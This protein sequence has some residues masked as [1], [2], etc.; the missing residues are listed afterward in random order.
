MGKNSTNDKWKFAASVV[1][2]RKFEGKETEILIN[3][4]LISA[5]KLKKEISRYTCPRFEAEV[6]SGKF[7]FLDLT[8]YDFCES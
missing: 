8:D 6:E 1:Q 7:C 2:K 5:E 4:R 3:E